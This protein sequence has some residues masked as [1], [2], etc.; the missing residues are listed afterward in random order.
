MIKVNLHGIK[1][2][3]N[4]FSEYLNLISDQI[5]LNDNSRDRVRGLY[6]IPNKFMDKYYK[7]YILEKIRKN[8]LLAEELKVLLK[9]IDKNA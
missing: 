1:S 2:K 8:P 9:E 5:Q 4:N 7:D 6:D 3:I